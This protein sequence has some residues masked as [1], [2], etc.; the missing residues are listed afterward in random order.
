MNHPGYIRVKMKAYDQGRLCAVRVVVNRKRKKE[1]AK[2][3]QPLSL[4]PFILSFR[5]K[6]KLHGQPIPAKGYGHILK[7][8]EP[9][10]SEH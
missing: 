7:V 5:Y 4:F 1:A 9:I 2:K 3:Q 6:C 8:Y 10:L